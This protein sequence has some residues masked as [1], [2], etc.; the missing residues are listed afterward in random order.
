V[1]PS[2]I[3]PETLR[4][5]A[6]CL[7]QLRHRVPQKF[8]SFD[9]G[10][11]NSQFRGKYIRNNLIRIFTNWVEHFTRRLP[12]PDPCSLCPVSSTRK[13]WRARFGRGLYLSEGGKLNEWITWLSY[14]SERNGSAEWLAL[15]LTIN[16]RFRMLHCQSAVS[17]LKA[18]SQM[19]GI[20]CRRHVTSA[21][22]QHH[23]FYKLW[24]AQLFRATN[25]CL[26][27]HFTFRQ[28]KISWWVCDLQQNG[29]LQFAT[30]RLFFL[31]PM[32]DST[33][34]LTNQLQ[35][36]YVSINDRLTQHFSKR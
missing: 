2:G 21:V 12:P 33:N 10:E 27:F 11:P 24:P 13:M 3:D 36:F 18:L 16:A 35:R 7:N 4:F 32:T 22:T 31:L 34:Q 19:R 30:E 14:H 1:T 6:Q 5:I 28:H 25:I 20:V 15:A 9:K 8:R 23:K 26:V 17:A 29:C